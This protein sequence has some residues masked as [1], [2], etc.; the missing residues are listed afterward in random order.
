M[1]KIDRK[2]GRKEECELSDFF[3]ISPKGVLQLTS[4]ILV[5]VESPK[6]SLFAATRSLELRKNKNKRR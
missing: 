5:H 6:N 4:A 1:Q 2:K 3:S